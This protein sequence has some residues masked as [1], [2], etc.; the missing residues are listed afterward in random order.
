VDLG[1]AGSRVVVTGG[2]GGIGSAIARSFLDEGAS[3]TICARSLDRLERT[4]TALGS[5]RVRAVR[6]D[7]GDPDAVRAL[8]EGTVE[9]SGGIDVVVTNA[10]ANAAG[11][12]EAEFAASF[13]VDLMQSVRLASALLDA[14]PERPF[15][16]VCLGSIDG[17]SGATPHHAYSVMKA[18]LLAWTKNA[19][20]SYGPL[21]IRVNAVC[22]GAI[23]F[24]G[25]W[26]D[27]VRLDDPDGFR[28]HVARIPGRRMGTPEEVAAVVTF[29]ASPRAS[30]VSGATVL[31]DGGE[32]ASVG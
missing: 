27:R 28:A 7:V 12:S 21:G 32:H 30:W 14:Q 26:W 16:M 9:A 13:D 29:L 8:V 15:S 19:A 6:A 20:V 1:L 24:P 25:G 2:S 4:R 17:M 31:V 22:P 10:T 11:A 23:L 18:A 3:V 5:D